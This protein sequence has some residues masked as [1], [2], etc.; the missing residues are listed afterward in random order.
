MT[1]LKPSSTTLFFAAKP[2]TIAKNRKPRVIE[3]NADE[4]PTRTSILADDEATEKIVRLVDVVFV[5][6]GEGS[7]VSFHV[8]VP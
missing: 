8:V 5:I 7:L 1:S 3:I 4:G 6:N 2:S